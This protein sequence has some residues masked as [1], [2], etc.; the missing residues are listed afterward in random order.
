[1]NNKKLKIA[2]VRQQYTPHGG[3]ER[4]VEN[5]LNSL[6]QYAEV[7]LT[8][9]TRKWSA[10]RAG[11]AHILICNPFFIGRLWR[12]WSF[13]KKACKLIEKKRSEFD[14]VQSHERILCADIYRAGEG[15]HREWLA[16]RARV[17][18][19]LGRIWD[20]TSP[21]HRYILKQE[22]AVFESRLLKKIIC[23]SNQT[24]REINHYFPQHHAPITV[25][26][27]A[28]DQSKFNPDLQKQHRTITRASL[29]FSEDDYIALFVGSGYERKGVKQ[30]LKVFSLLE[31]HY[32]LVIIGKDRDL[33]LYLDY[34]KS[35]QLGQRVRFLGPQNDIL[36]FLG[37]ADLF[38]F[39]SLYD[40]LPNST[41][42]AAATGLPVIASKTTGAAD[43]TRS[44]G[45]E[46]PDPLDTMA[47]VAAIKM[48][49][50][51]RPPLADLTANSQEVMSKKLWA[52]YQHIT[53]A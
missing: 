9:I 48:A 27:N 52:L 31:Q 38:V 12:D 43:I 20:K 39:P 32:K 35:L 33:S 13:A 5:M 6:N 37:A 24:R 10:P 42:E 3:A 18:S 25:I 19:W 47:W 8:L 30:L 22:K 11:E 29:N 50:K 17:R 21:Y 23:N 1:M 28:V 34:A 16:Q 49:K 44:Q 53:V 40:P 14:I 2:I 26:S 15:V 46:A 41:L 7:E 45:I 36:P 4:F 51:N